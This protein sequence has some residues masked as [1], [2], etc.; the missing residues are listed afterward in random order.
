MSED[1]GEVWVRMRGRTY[2][3]FANATCVVLSWASSP[4]KFLECSY[5]FYF[6]IF[7]ASRP[8]F[9]VLHLILLPILLLKL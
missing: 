1:G 5:S 3:I 6:S 4:L 9:L 7:C 8:E 2:N